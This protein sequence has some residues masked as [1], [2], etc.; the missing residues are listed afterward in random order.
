MKITIKFI[1]LSV[2]LALLISCLPA[3]VFAAP[4]EIE[5]DESVFVNLDYYGGVSQY[6]I[7]KGVQ[8]NGNTQIHDFGNYKSVNNMTDYSKPNINP[9]GVDWN[10]SSDTERFYYECVMADKTGE[11]P[12]TFDISYKLNGEQTDAEQLAGKSGLVEITIHAIP[13]PKAQAYYRNNMVLQ[14]AMLVDM[15]NASSIDAPGA[16]LQSFGSHKLVLFMAMPGEDETFTISIGAENFES[17]G[18]IMAMAPATLSQLDMINDLRDIKNTVSDAY[19]AGYQSYNDLLDVIASMEGGLSD[20]KSGIEAID[21]N[22][23]DKL[24]SSSTTA[25]IGSLAA[26]F[27]SL[28]TKLNEIK[29]HLQSGKDTAAE[30]F[31]KADVLSSDTD[32]LRTDI[33][34]YKSSLHD[35]QDTAS[36]FLRIINSSSQT[37]DFRELTEKL[38]AQ[39]D[40]LS[41]NTAALKNSFTSLSGALGDMRSSIR[42]AERELRSFEGIEELKAEDYYKI[43]VNG[44]EIDVSKIPALKQI[45]DSIVSRVNNRIGEINAVLGSASGRFDILLDD[46]ENT[47]AKLQNL[48]TNTALALTDADDATDCARE[49]LNILDKNGGTFDTV[50][51]LK[52]AAV[53][54]LNKLIDLCGRASG[55]IDTV[56]DEISGASALADSITSKRESVLSA[57]DTAVTTS[58]TLAAVGT[59]AAKML[60]S[61]N[62]NLSLGDSG[63]SASK[64][65]LNGAISILQKSLDSAYVTNSLKNAGNIINDTIGNEKDKIDDETNIFE[66]DPNA[67]LQS[68]T[69]TQNP[70][71]SSIQVILR[72]EEISLD[73]TENNKD[74]EKKA[75]DRGALGRIADIFIKLFHAIA[76]VFTNE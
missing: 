69:S 31:D 39:T 55:T 75:E 49:L 5:T 13:N 47:L 74:I 68:F 10:I 25:A 58:D 62:E 33:E 34:S 29:P 37:Y 23:I 12:W 59:D 19:H 32:A 15:E 36:E 3:A 46:L 38:R 52:T 65:A 40:I 7:V 64:E 42:K 4:A 21:S 61:F 26:D 6:S 1:S 22:V 53:D 71:P 43:T 2:I 9:S 17:M 72:T 24:D 41:E 76:S 28:N 54:S 16:Q 70:T 14:A 27:D 57:M 30:M 73:S 50:D 56:S 60:R 67:P 51:D 35:A 11:L 45:I 66:L 18:V 20:V 8:M 44:K 48:L 63:K